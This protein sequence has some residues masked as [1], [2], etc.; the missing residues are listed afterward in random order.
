MDEVRNPR[1]EISGLHHLAL[2]VK[3]MDRTIEF[4]HRILG[5]PLIK[6]IDIPNGRGQHFFFDVGN[7]ASL[8]FFYF[9]DAPEAAPGIAN[10][11]F[12][13][14]VSA[15]GSMHHVA[16]RVPADKLQEYRDILVA[17]GVEVTETW[18]HNDPLDDITVTEQPTSFLGSI[19][20]TDP[21]GIIL[22]L[23]DWMRPIHPST[24]VHHDRVVDASGN[25]RWIKREEAVA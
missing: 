1:F 11:P 24:D 20:F 7:G 15:H 16:F 8:A 9:P 13:Q 21:D 3:D 12:P 17:E 4:Y 10:P 6:T 14:S 19:Y 5:M 2:V 22:E 25:G 18:Y 23:A